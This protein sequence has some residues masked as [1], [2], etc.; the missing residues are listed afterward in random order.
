MIF[1]VVSFFT[2]Y[3]YRY[4]VLRLL[5]HNEIVTYA[6]PESI[7]TDIQNELKNVSVTPTNVNDIRQYLTNKLPDYRFLASQGSNDRKE[8]YYSFLSN[9]YSITSKNAANLFNEDINITFKNQWFAVSFTPIFTSYLNIYRNVAIGISIVLSMLLFFLLHWIKK[10]RFFQKIF[11]QIKQKENFQWIHKLS[12]KII[13]INVFAILIALSC[14]YFMYQNRY[15]FFEFAKESIGLKEDYNDIVNRIQHETEDLAF[16]KASKHEITKVLNNY[17]SSKMQLSLYNETATHYASGGSTIYYDNVNAMQVVDHVIAL[18]SPF[19]YTYTITIGTQ[20]GELMIYVYPLLDFV[21]PYMITIVFVAF[22]FYLLISLS[23]IKKKVKEIET[24]KEDILFLA[25]GDWEHEVDSNGS[26]E[27]AQLGDN[28]N[29][30]RSMLLENKQVEEEARKSNKDLITSMS[31]DLRTPLTSLLGYLDIIRLNKYTTTEQ[32]TSYL[33][34]CVEKVNQINDLSN[35]TFE[36]ALVFE[37][38]EAVVMEHVAIKEISQ[39]LKKNLHFLTLEG[40][41]LDVQCCESDASIEANRSMI[42]RIMNNLISN[43]SKYGDRGKPIIISM[44]IEKEQLVLNFCNEK[45]IQ[46]D[47]VERNRI[48]LKSVKRMVELHQGNFYVNDEE[49]RFMVILRLPLLMN[50]K[51][52]II[53]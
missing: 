17:S 49:H 45:M 2:I 38:N 8:L 6:I 28:L 19:V 22:S 4:D 35:K 25:N 50:Q 40:F 9:G 44:N 47:V 27:I 16:N 32:Y 24:I 36:Y 53:Q 30:M 11:D 13:L 23:Y 18:E 29:Q 37:S 14:F 31:H 7:K 20:S 10:H 46:Q 1:G 43:I 52:N 26:D 34:L 51:P 41:I 39:D 5:Q 48:G 15:S 42:H 21:D 12:L 3:A 33:N